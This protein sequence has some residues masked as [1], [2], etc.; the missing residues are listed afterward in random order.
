MP[1]LHIVLNISHNMAA[2]VPHI[3]RGLADKVETDDLPTAVHL[4]RNK[5][6]DI[7]GTMSTVRRSRNF[8]PEEGNT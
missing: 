1:Q 3:L 2:E 4:I 6:G 5:S 8:V 7:A